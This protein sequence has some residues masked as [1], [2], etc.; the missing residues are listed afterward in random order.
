MTKILKRPLSVLLAVLMIAG[1]FAVVPMSASADA[2]AA[3]L[4]IGENV[5]YYD[6]FDAAVAAVNA[7]TSDCTLTVLKT[8]D[9]GKNAAFTNTGDIKITLSVPSG[10]TLNLKNPSARDN[11]GTFPM[12]IEGCKNFHINGEGTIHLKGSRISRSLWITNGSVV[13]IEDGIHFTFEANTNNDSTWIRCIWVDYSK[14]DILGG[15][16]TAQD[17]SIR[18]M[19]MVVSAYSGTVVNI[20]GGHIGWNPKDQS[21]A[22]TL[23]A[24][25]NGKINVY[26]G[27]IDGVLW[28]QNGTPLLEAYSL[29]G[30][31]FYGDA[32][33]RVEYDN[34]QHF[35]LTTISEIVGDKLKVKSISENPYFAEVVSAKCKAIS[36]DENAGTATV[37]G[38]AEK[39]EYFGTEVTF[40]ATPKSGYSFV[41]WKRGEA[42]VSTDATY[43]YT[44]SNTTAGDEEIELTATFKATPLD[45]LNVDSA[46]INDGNAFGLTDVDYLMGTLL[47]VQKKSVAGAGTSS[48]E[49][50]QD[51]RFVA[52]LDTDIIQS[53]E[54]EDY[55]FVI[56]KLNNSKTF[57]NTNFDN[58]K[59]NWGNGEKTISC[60]GTYNTVCGNNAYG[61]PTDS[62]TAYKYI[63]CGVNGVT[64]SEKVVARFYVK[65]NGTYYYA[66]YAGHDYKYTGC[67]VGWDDLV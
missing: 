32:V 42:T 40:V 61:D 25:A 45:P 28:V 43:K 1:L 11:A 50:G 31:K 35:N 57:E 8:V 59:A 29:Y 12:R 18:N 67:L 20:Y 63:T 23:D 54:T 4:T 16:Y 55:G 19:S 37:D 38:V 10:V 3:S 64:G 52:C 36:S 5:T 58:L 2:P 65:I 62:S 60:K 14:L 46:S 9:E 39:N 49:T 6:S 41:E 34:K 26:G 30:G 51:M 21:K 66:K 7:A 33:A 48:Q 22:G 47:G 13:T 53:P 56:A 24:A 17:N 44:P 15:D 27:Y